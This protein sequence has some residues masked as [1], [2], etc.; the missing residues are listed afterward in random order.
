MFKRIIAL[1]ICVVLMFTTMCV[2]SAATEKKVW[3]P[4]LFVED[5]TATAN[6]E[7]FVNIQVSNNEGGIMAFTLSL[8]YD[9][10]ALTYVGYKKGIFKDSNMYVVK[11]DGYIAMVDCESG[12]KKTDGTM[13]TLIFTVN[14]DVKG[15]TYPFKIAHVRPKTNGENLK[16]CLANKAGDIITPTVKNGNLIIPTTQ[17]N[18]RHNFS[19][20]EEKVAVTCVSDGTE[21]RVCENCG[22]N[23]N[24][25]IDKTG[26]HTYEKEWT[27]DTAATEDSDGVMSRHCKNCSKTTDVI[28]FPYESVK[29]AVEESNKQKDPDQEIGFNNQV[30]DI[31]AVTEKIVVENYKPETS[32]SQ[33]TTQDSTESQ[34]SDSQSTS[35]E[36]YESLVDEDAVANTGADE[37]VGQTVQVSAEPKGIAAKA[38]SFLYGEDGDGGIINAIINAF[39]EFIEKLFK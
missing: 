31:V 26:I 1:I 28:Y 29:E 16:D 27:V 11:K 20:W 6:D 30:G 19:K 8:M 39:K 2:V 14:S 5:I 21:V 22:K 38:Y 36:E 18:C 3:S 34:G 12:N 10:S 32:Q 24:R 33:D 9:E 13:L 37:L 25:T 23:E 7:I 17:E 15:G 4:C 35:K